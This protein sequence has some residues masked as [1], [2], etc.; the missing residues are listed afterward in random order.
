MHGAC[1][2]EKAHWPRQVDVDACSV[3][4]RRGISLG[5]HRVRICTPYPWVE[6]QIHSGGAMPGHVSLYANVN[7]EHGVG[8]VVDRISGAFTCAGIDEISRLFS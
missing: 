6:V 7:I 1:I 2:G 4:S 8:N 5:A 3:V